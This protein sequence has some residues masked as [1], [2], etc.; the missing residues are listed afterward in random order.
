MLGHLMFP[1][2]GANLPSIGYLGVGSM[3]HSAWIGER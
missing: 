1:I 2:E 3:K